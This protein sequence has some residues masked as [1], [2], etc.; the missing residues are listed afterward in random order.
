MYIP[1]EDKY[2]RTAIIGRVGIELGEPP[3]PSRI[4]PDLLPVAQEIV[5]D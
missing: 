2:E 5:R 1:G 4:R 3:S